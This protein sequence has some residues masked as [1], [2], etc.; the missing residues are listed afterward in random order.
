[1]EKEILEAVKETQHY[2]F[3]ISILLMAILITITC[4][5]KK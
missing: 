4:I 5:Y 2:L 1:M 3:I